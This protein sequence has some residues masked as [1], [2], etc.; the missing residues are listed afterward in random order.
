M[1]R[2]EAVLARVTEAGH[3]KSS[4]YSLPRVAD[5]FIADFSSLIN[6]S[7]ATTPNR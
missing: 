4:E 6:N 1:V 5:R 7:D 3:R 2:D